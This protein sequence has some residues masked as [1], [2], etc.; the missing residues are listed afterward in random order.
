MLPLFTF[1]FNHNIFNDLVY[2]YRSIFCPSVLNVFLFLFFLPFLPQTP[3]TSSEKCKGHKYWD[4]SLKRIH[5][6]TFNL[7]AGLTSLGFI[8]TLQTF[9]LLVTKEENQGWQYSCCFNMTLIKHNRIY[10][11]PFSTEPSPRQCTDSWDV[12]SLLM[13][14]S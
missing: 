7:L 11:H 8:H 9:L 2:L 13:I 3:L 12:V 10:G 1:H 4:E 5:W 6:K 14:Y